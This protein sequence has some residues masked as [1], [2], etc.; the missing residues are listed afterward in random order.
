MVGMLG[1]GLARGFGL[2]L[3]AYWTVYL[4]RRLF[5]PL[6]MAWINQHSQSEVRATVISIAG[7]VDAVGQIAGG[8]L[9]GLIATVFSTGAAIAAAGCVLAPALLLYRLTLRHVAAVDQE[10]GALAAAGD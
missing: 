7:Q 8:P 4:M 6:Y 5:D 10:S 2:G 3:G 1:F 9:F